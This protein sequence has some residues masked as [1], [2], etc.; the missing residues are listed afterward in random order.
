MNKAEKLL[1]KVKDDYNKIAQH[2]SQ[3]RYAPWDEFKLFKEYIKDGQKILDSGSGNSR[4]YRFFKEQKLNVDYYGLDISEKLIEDAKRKYP[5]ISDH[6]KVGDI[7]KLPYQDSQFDVIISIATFHH[8]PTKELRLQSLSEIYR[9]LK[10]GGYLLMTNWHLWHK[11]YLKH[12][13]N[14]FSQKISWNDF[15]KPWKSPD[16][17]VQIQRYIHGFTK[18]ELK[19]LLIKSGFNIEKLFTYSN[20]HTKEIGRRVNLEIIA[21][22]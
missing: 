18:G 14:Q 6:L 13:F 8:L 22:K 16:G 1:Q 20:P 15:F 7:I 17:E 11:P 3:T 10:P 19:R 12:F 5:E 2:F 4:L 21:S 9:V